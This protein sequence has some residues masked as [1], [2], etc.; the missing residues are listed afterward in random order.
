M[1]LCEVMQAKQFKVKDKNGIFVAMEPSIFSPRQQI[2]MSIL[3][4]V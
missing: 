3:I 1:K 2:T 4:P